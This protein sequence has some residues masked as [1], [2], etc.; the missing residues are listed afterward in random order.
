[1]PEYAP[2]TPSWVDLSSPEPALH[3]PDGRFAALIDPQGASVTV[4]QPARSS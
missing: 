1:M 2:G 3:M 4:M